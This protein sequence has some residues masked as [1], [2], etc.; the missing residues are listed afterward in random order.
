MND[1]SDGEEYYMEQEES[2]RS[3]E[4]QKNLARQSNQQHR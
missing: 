3:D 4:V 1:I 2:E